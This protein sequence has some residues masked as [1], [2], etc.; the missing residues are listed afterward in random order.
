MAVAAVNAMN[1]QRNGRGA[2]I[3]PAIARGEQRRTAVGKNEYSL[4]RQQLSSTKWA[5]YGESRTRP[6]YNDN[7][8]S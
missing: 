4:G 8:N 2:F 1:A 6:P 3:G 7:I 5:G